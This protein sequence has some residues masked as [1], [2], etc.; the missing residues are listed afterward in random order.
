VQ[1]VSEVFD[2]TYPPAQARRLLTLGY[3]V[4]LT[5]NGVSCLKVC[6]SLVQHSEK[7]C[8]SAGG[9]ALHLCL[10]LILSFMLCPLQ[11][12]GADVYKAFQDNFFAS[13]VNYVVRWFRRST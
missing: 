10:H 11:A 2:N 6:P 9:A 3:Y 5:G 12:M 8:T 7:I 4:S 13:Q 1:L